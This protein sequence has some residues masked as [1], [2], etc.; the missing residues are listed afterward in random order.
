ML[1]VVW[2]RLLDAL[3]LTTIMMRET[4][5][6]TASTHTHDRVTSH[7][8]TILNGLI[9][10]SHRF[11]TRFEHLNVGND[12]AKECAHK[13]RRTEGNRKKSLSILE[14]NETLTN[15]RKW[16]LPTWRCWPSDRCPCVGS[17][18]NLKKTK[19][20][21]KKEKNE[22]PDGFLS[23]TVTHLTHKKCNS[24]MAQSR[25]LCFEHTHSHTFEF[26]LFLLYLFIFFS[27][28]FCGRGKHVE[29]IKT[30]AKMRESRRRRK[31]NTVRMAN[32]WSAHLPSCEADQR[33][34]GSDDTNQM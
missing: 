32:V 5:H 3:T 31:K 8:Y 26:G 20:K 11:V 28:A 10:F 30:L 27:F 17:G 9:S 12:R 7:M 6:F 19:D 18:A 23:V 1:L 24:L 4:R 21:R 25:D 2:V 34:Q 22:I 29:W 13:P 15:E 14:K 16:I 33:L